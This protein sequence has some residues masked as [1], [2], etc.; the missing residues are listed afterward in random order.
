MRELPP[1]RA[2]IVCSSISK[3][4]CIG[5][6]MANGGEQVTKDKIFFEVLTR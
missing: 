4:I 6:S 2:N 3:D 1:N 5:S